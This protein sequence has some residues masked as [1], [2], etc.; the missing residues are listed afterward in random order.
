MIGLLLE[1]L[2]ACGQT[3]EADQMITGDIHLTG[4]DRKYWHVWGDPS[5]IQVGLRPAPIKNDDT[6]FTFQIFGKQVDHSRL[7]SNPNEVVDIFRTVTERIDLVYGDIIWFSEFRPTARMVHKF[8][9]GRVFVIGDAAH[10][11][12]PTGGQGLNSSIQ[13]AFNLSWKLAL[14]LK[15]HVLPPKSLSLLDSYTFERLPVISEMLSQTTAL[16]NQTLQAKEGDIKPWARGGVLKQLGVNYRGSPI[17]LDERTTEDIKGSP[18]SN[19]DGRI[20]AGD[21]SPD[22]PGLVN[23]SGKQTRLFDIF[24]PWL[25]TVLI[26]GDDLAPSVLRALRRYPEKTIQTFCIVPREASSSAQLHADAVLEDRGGHAYTGYAVDRARSTVIVVR[27][28]G[29]IGAVVFGAEGTKQYFDGMFD[30]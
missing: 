28:D 2:Q 21:R 23:S 30:A 10:V 5:T 4:L 19:E 12:S 8:G 27:P 7:M 16:L 22:A 29:V 26:F 14:V 1:R 20:C 25:H 15:N 24:K 6:V 17:V 3:R 11:H 18:Y 9:E 13:D